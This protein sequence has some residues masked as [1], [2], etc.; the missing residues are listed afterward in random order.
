MLKLKRKKGKSTTPDPVDY[1]P[2][3]AFLTIN[4]NDCLC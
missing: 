1:K 3:I 2:L 4:K